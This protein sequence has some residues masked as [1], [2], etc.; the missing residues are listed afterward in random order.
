MNAGCII[1]PV[2]ASVTARQAS[3]VLALLWSPG[4][5]FT[6]IITN[7]LSR[8][9]KGQVMLLTMTFKIKLIQTG[10]VSCVSSAAEVLAKFERE[11]FVMLR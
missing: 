8:T 6:A 1:R 2:A 3:R 11:K 5:L 4:L 9:V 7:K 10:L